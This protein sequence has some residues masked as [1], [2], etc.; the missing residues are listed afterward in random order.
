MFTLLIL[1]LLVWI[2]LGLYHTHKPLPEG[3]SVATPMR[4]AG[5]V[6][7]LADATWTDEAGTRHLDQ[8]IFDRV[9][10]LIDEAEQLLVLDMFLIN[11]FAGETVGTGMRPLSREIAEALRAKKRARPEMP[12]IVITDPLNT[13]YGGIENP[14]LRDLEAAGVE[15]V[16][17]RLE[18]LR[19]SNPLWS[20]L[21]RMCCQWLGNSRR[22]GWFSNPVGDEPVP[23]RSVLALLN[24]KA[25]HRKTLV[26]DT[27][28]GLTGLVTSA[29][30]H[31]ASSAHD[32]VALEFTGPAA[33]DLLETERAVIRFSRP[34]LE[35]P[36]SA[37]P[38]P[39]QQPDSGVRLRVLTEAAIRDGV[40]ALI[41][42]AEP[43]DRLDMA[44]FYL[45]HRAVVDGLITAHR[46]G[47]EVRVLLDPN[48]AAFGRDKDGIPNRAVAAE[49]HRAGITVRW[50][51]TRGEQCHAKFLM[52]HPANGEV[53]FLLGSANMTRRNLD[54]LNLETSIHAWA[55]RKSRV[56]GDAAAFFE[57]RW[58]NTG[59]YLHSVSHEDEQV[60]W[61]YYWRYRF[62][63]ATG[64]STF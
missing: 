8:A 14:V 18:A 60:G 24:F 62:M 42:R 33:R 35:W 23:L 48:V 34:G 25:N 21:W 4:G 50:C 37:V 57:R 46:R 58:S 36:Q 59:G 2:G 56:A 15:V 17:T 12:V 7:L 26:A 11:D 19:D 51:R 27:P 22:G 52:R 32:N 39:A 53:E 54:D 61:L 41:E 43:G 40:M 38:D 45:A 3:L 44:M 55:D 16:F 64:V 47:V 9:F 1:L 63:E 29:N 31:D 20:G 5:H 10:T 49:L 13:L 6:R 28:Q 30:P